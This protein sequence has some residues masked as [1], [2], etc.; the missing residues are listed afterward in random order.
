MRV[1]LVTGTVGVGKSTVGY[2]VAQEASARGV[3]AAFL[4][5]DELSRL[6]PAP[7]GDPFNTALILANLRAVTG[8][9]RAA[10]AELL[11]LAWVVTDAE[12]LAALERAVGTPVTAVR[13]TAEAAVV[14]DRLRMRHQGPERDGLDWHL[15][16]APELVGIQDRG[17]TLPVVEAGG[18]VDVVAAAV[19]ERLTELS[20]A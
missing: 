4:D 16:R 2:A 3:P 12:D 19:L 9:Y 6:W 8:N 17:L 10:G 7:D 11:V 14:A 1:G 15:R 13:L 5:V 20:P 18:P